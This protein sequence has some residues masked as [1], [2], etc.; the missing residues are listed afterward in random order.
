LISSGGN[1]FL[2]DMLKWGLSD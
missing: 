2:D 1:Y